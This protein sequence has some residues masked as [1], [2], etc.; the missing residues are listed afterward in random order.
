MNLCDISS[1]R[2]VQLLVPTEGR[3]TTE[4]R[5]ISRPAALTSQTLQRPHSPRA[6]K[7]AGASACVS[8]DLP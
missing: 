3:S 5:A 7:I 1:T 2:E 6:T 8:D 4:V